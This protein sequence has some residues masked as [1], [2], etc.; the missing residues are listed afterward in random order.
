MVNVSSPNTPGL[1]ALQEKDALQ[2]L[3]EVTEHQFCETKP[4]SLLLKIAPDLTM[5]S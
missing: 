3:S 2:K 4:C 5:N 1:R